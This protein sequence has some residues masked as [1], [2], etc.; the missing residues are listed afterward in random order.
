MSGWGAPLTDKGAWNPVS[1]VMPLA[2]SDCER[3]VHTV[4]PCSLLSNL[5]VPVGYRSVQRL[6]AEMGHPAVRPSCRCVSPDPICFAQTW[7]E[8]AAQHSAGSLRTAS[9]FLLSAQVSRR[10]AFSTLMRLTLMSMVSGPEAAS[11]SRHR[12]RARPL[13]QDPA[14]SHAECPLDARPGLN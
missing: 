1:F 4:A 14:V 10:V 5:C 2:A 13:R 9:N 6:L 7:A 8:F 3:S 12:C 11:R